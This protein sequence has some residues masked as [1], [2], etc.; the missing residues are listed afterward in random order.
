VHGLDPVGHRRLAVGEHGQRDLAAAAL[1]PRDLV[2][3][4]PPLGAA[5]ASLEAHP[6][7][8]RRHGWDP[9]ALGGHNRREQS[10]REVSVGADQDAVKPV[11]Q[12][13]HVAGADLS[14]RPVSGDREVAHS[15]APGDS[16]QA[17]VADPVIDRVGGVVVAVGDHRRE[18]S[19]G[20]GV[21]R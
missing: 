11:H 14:V 8:L 19:T 5:P 16:E 7:S 2:H 21:E 13:G 18:Q 20:P 17:G 1:E 4:L 3:E 6:P 9:P 10:G 15:S 12:P